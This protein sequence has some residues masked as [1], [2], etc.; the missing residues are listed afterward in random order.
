MPVGAA[1]W[2]PDEWARLKARQGMAH[3]TA[4]EQRVG[5][6]AMR[7]VPAD[8]ATMGEARPARPQRRFARYFVSRTR[9][10]L[11]RFG[12]EPGVRVRLVEQ[13]RGAEWL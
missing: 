8:G 1:R 12:R 4:G 5:D 6:A 7:D 10:M 3:I 9:A 11:A 2:S 13:S